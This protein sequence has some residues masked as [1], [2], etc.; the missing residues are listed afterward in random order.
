MLLAH[1]Q[2]WSGSNGSSHLGSQPQYLAINGI[3]HSL[4]WTPSRRTQ[5]DRG[6]PLPLVA[7]PAVQQTSTLERNLAAGEYRLFPIGG[8]QHSL[9]AVIEHIY[10]PLPAHLFMVRLSHDAGDYV[11]FPFPITNRIPT[12]NSIIRF[13]VRVVEGEDVAH[14]S[15]EVEEALAAGAYIEGR[16]GR[17]RVNGRGMWVWTGFALGDDG[18]WELSIV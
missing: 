12:V 13:V 1:S 5:R 6:N 14:A 7:L 3:Q 9:P 4:P 17:L 8:I 2:L 10:P 16:P 18:V 15:W 11:M